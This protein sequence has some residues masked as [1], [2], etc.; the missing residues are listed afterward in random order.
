MAA[1]VV[2][3]VITGI[4]AISREAGIARLER[5]K[6]EA[7]FEDVRKLANS[8]MFELHDAIQDLPGAT[9]AREL[10][11]KRASE[12]LDRLSAGASGNTSL[13][14]E[15]A[16]AYE[17]VGDIQA[18][19]GSESVGNTKG[20]VDSY[21]KALQIRET[22][23][24][25]GPSP[26]T[27]SNVALLSSKLGS[28]LETAGDFGA[29]VE[30]D[31]RA[32]EIAEQLYRSDPAANSNRLA[33]LAVRMGFHQFMQ[34]DWVESRKMYDRGIQILEAARAAH[35][36]G[37]ATEQNLA[38]AYKKLG[39][40]AL[41]QS[42]WDE[43]LASY[44]KALV[45]TTAGPV[46]QSASARS[47]LDLAYCYLGIGDSLSGKG[48][49]SA[50]L[51]HY[52]RAE[53]IASRAVKAD[54]NDMR[55]V[56]CLGDSHA[57]LGQALTGKGDPQAGLRYL[58]SS[59]DTFERVH[60]ADPLQADIQKSAGQSSAT[61]A[62]ACVAL[63]LRPGTSRAQQAVF[64][65]RAESAYEQA[66]KSFADLRARGALAS[67]AAAEPERVEKALT[68]CRSALAN[69]HAPSLMAG[70]VTQ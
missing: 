40:L 12:Y 66:L 38:F 69:L 11:V 30:S 34:G 27:R 39:K 23:A 58:Q 14:D 21:R 28:A 53:E 57:A 31:R 56:S 15:L 8:L 59:V 24:A 48:D 1:V 50:A 5:N 62:D 17:K 25:A 52:Q 70:H 61:L 63:A 29:A 20:A 37:R 16:S 42:M 65:H 4:V 18:N 6:A 46:S 43:A 45:A 26:R 32:V 54:P 7:R 41:R 9:R 47:Q 35:T 68:K 64:W 2:V 55:A 51:G 10:L 49:Y 3:T 33:V 22:L 67:D 44:Q 60:A 19:T 36:G 13:Q